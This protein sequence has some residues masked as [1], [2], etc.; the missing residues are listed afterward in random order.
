MGSSGGTVTHRDRDD[1]HEDSDEDGD[2]A[3]GG[4]EGEFLEFAHGGGAGDQDGGD[5]AKPDCAGA[6]AGECVEGDGEAE[7]TCA[8]AEDVGDDE[9]GA[10]DLFQYAAAD[11]F[12]HVCDA[13]TS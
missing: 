7:D 8:G 10:D 12:G 6:V 9:E 2:E 1:D 4:E 3:G 5:E 11:L 13:M